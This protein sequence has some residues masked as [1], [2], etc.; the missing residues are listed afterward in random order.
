MKSYHD[1]FDWACKQA[2]DVYQK[3]GSHVPMIIPLKDGHVAGVT[4]PPGHPAAFMNGGGVLNLAKIMGSDSK[5]PV[6]AFINQVFVQLGIDA[7]LFISEGWML[8]V[9]MDDL[10]DLGTDE[11]GRKIVPR[12]A[13]SP[14]RVEVIN[15]VLDTREYQRQRIYTIKSG[16][17]LGLAKEIDSRTPTK[18]G[19]PAE[20][21][22]GLF[23]NLHDPNWK[24]LGNEYHVQDK[25]DW[26]R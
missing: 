2:Q 5:E 26:N 6:L 3:D 21:A 15:V 16:K 18:S 22:I 7:Y 17:V 25:K 11:Q 24:D 14:D 1:I 19:K 4:F 10:P 12:A 13:D 9:S 23:M 20:R 8:D